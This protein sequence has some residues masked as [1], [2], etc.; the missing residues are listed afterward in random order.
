MIALYPIYFSVCDILYSHYVHVKLRSTWNNFDFD[1]QHANIDLRIHGQAVNF[2]VNLRHV[3]VDLQ[4]H[5]QVLTG[6]K[7]KLQKPHQTATRAWHQEIIYHCLNS[8]A[9]YRKLSGPHFHLVGM[10]GLLLV[11]HGIPHLASPSVRCLSVL[12]W[13]RYQSHDRN[14]QLMAWYFFLYHM[15]SQLLRI[16][17]SPA[18]YH[19]ISRYIHI[20]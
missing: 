19:S 8:A 12:D 14:V 2:K 5:S 10:R 20:N 13:C 17:G 3:N 4:I 7:S 9:Q 15:P 18:E 11:P 6:H 16:V 1:L